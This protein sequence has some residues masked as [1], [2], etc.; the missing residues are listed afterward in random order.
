MSKCIKCNIEIKDPGEKCP[1]CGRALN[2]DG[3]E[4]RTYPDAIR[5]TKRFR[6][7]F[8]II[9]FLSLVIGTVCFVIN[10]TVLKDTFWSGI[11]I[12]ILTYFNVYMELTLR[13]KSNHIFNLVFLVVVGVIGLVGIDY[14]SGYYGWAMDFVF[15]GGIIFTDFVILV[16]VIANRRGWQ[17]Y[18]MAQIIMILLSLLYGLLLLPQITRCFPLFWVALGCSSFLFLGTL[19]IG[20]Y[21]ARSELIRRFHV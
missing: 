6:T 15:P 10:L 2:L 19:I 5:T 17:N 11:P 18:L 4:S 13:G 14:F 12:L 8:N 16:L 21:K 20:D 3:L 1:L 9:R 7:F